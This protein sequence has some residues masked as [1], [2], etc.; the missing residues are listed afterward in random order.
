VLLLID[1]W[2]LER[3]VPLRRRVVEKLPLVVMA[4][5]VSLVTFIVQRRAGG[6]ASLE[7]VGIVDRLASA[8]VGY[9]WYVEKTLW[10]SGLAVFYP[11][12]LPIPFRA[13]ALSVVF[14]GGMTVVA[15]RVRRTRPWVFVGWF[16]YLIALLPVIGF[17]RVGR[18]AVA[19]RFSYIPGIGLAIMVAWSGAELVRAH[20]SMK[21]V[22]AVVAAAV[23]GAFAAATRTQVGYWRNDVALYEH[24]LAVT[25]DNFVAHT[26]LGSAL[27]AQNRVPEALLHYREALRIDPDAGEAH[28][29]VGVA[30]AASG[31]PAG[32]LAAFGRALALDDHDA[33]T[34]VRAADVLAREGRLDEAIAHYRE[35]AALE[36]ESADVHNNLGFLLAAKGELG[37]AVEQYMEALRDDPS[38]GTAHNNLA[39]ALEALGQ[40]DE[41]LRHYARAVELAPGN[42]QHRLNHAFALLRAGR[43]ESAV[44]ELRAILRQQ[45]DSRPAA[46]QLVQVL[47][48]DANPAGRA[49]GV[50]LAE[51]LARRMPAPDAEVLSILAVAYEGA[52][53]FDDALRSWRDAV[54]AAAAGGRTDLLPRL[55][56]ALSACSARATPTPP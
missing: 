43:R 39:L 5:V 33:G 45:P 40:R 22:A 4:G 10:P 3:R 37:D 51:E 13:L 50:A 32:A 44:D 31:D 23:L 8:A 56:A 38:L 6:V 11:L 55:E 7:R 18:Q 1:V 29:N 2:P 52:G 30:L 49:E 15:W 9:A 47:A 21:P 19:D 16:W 34:H 28:S 17:V 35:A 36:P 12:R 54:A 25:Q 20:R 24:A 27:L 42:P 26:N 48:A 41:A 14:V 53:R 46:Q